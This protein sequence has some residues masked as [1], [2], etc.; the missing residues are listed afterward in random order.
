MGGRGRDAAHMRRMRARR[1]P[2][3]NA[4]DGRVKRQVR[5]AFWMSRGAPLTTTQ[6]LRHCYP[7]ETIWGE[8]YRSWHRS[9]ILFERSIWSP[10]ASGGRRAG[11]DL[12]GR[13]THNRRSVSRLIY[14]GLL[15]EGG[16]R[17]LA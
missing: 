1:A 3:T 2:F 11:G 9:N 15:H 6:L 10:F 16:A 13:L 8:R 5:W 17:M 12:L 4:R 14:V 7:V